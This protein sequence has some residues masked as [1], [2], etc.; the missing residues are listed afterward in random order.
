MHEGETLMGI[1]DKHLD[2][3][4]NI[5]FA[6]VSIYK[7]HGDLRDSSVMRSL[8]ALIEWYRADARGH[9]PKEPRLPEKEALIFEQVKLMCEIRLGREEVT[10]ELESLS[11]GA[12]TVDDILA[13]L[14]K[15]RR[16][17]D[18]WNKR[19]GKQGYLQ[20]VSTYIK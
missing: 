10:A 2:V 16:S 19:G 12:K 13:C 3:L 15:I 8:D 9:T 7:K 18:K 4:Q 14:R 11:A 1:E 6:I 20:F 17:A 5:E